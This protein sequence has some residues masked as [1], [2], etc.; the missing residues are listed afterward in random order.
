MPAAELMYV[1][2][3]EKT[4]LHIQGQGIPQGFV[5][6]VSSVVFRPFKTHQICYLSVLKFVIS[7]PLKQHGMLK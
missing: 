2:G 3:V 5:R 4:L 7:P 1:T 6:V